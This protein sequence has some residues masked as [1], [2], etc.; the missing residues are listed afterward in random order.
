MAW[1]G[2]LLGGTLGYML[3]GPLGAMLG[4]A[5]GGN[6]DK[7]LGLSDQFESGAQE[8]VQAAFFSATFSIMG[9]IAKSDGRVTEDNIRMA[10]ATMRQMRLN[11]TQSKEAIR[12]FSEGKEADFNLDMALTELL[13]ACHRN[14]NLL[15]MFVEIQTQAAFS[16]GTLGT[17]QEN[18]DI[19]FLLLQPE[20]CPRHQRKNIHEHSRKNVLDH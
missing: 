5:L 13:Q 16:S 19:F 18:S 4:V 15:Q 17:K 9:H 7:G 6:F 2:K 12:L 14:R 11:E 20:L 1:W 10:R 3:G 8:R